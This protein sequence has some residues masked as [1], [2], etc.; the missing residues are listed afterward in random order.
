MGGAIRGA[1]STS[2]PTWTACM[3]PLPRANVRASQLGQA[4]G[5]YTVSG[6]AGRP[7]RMGHVKRRRRGA[8]QSATGPGRTGAGGPRGKRARGLPGRQDP[9]HALAG[10]DGSRPRR[11]PKRRR[12]PT[13]S[14]PARVGAGVEVRAS[15]RCPRRRSARRVG[16]TESARGA[17]LQRRA[18]R[19]NQVVTFHDVAAESRAGRSARSR[20]AGAARS[21][22]PPPPERPAG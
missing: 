10:L 11:S 17:G 4:G 14:S 21:P 15:W 16:G 5:R 9:D 3:G 22:S 12:V 6:G 13:R 18:T 8:A 19:P 2:S 20:A 1:R 7:S